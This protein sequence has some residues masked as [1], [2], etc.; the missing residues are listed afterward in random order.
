[1]GSTGEEV[2]TGG[3]VTPCG[4]VEIPEGVLRADGKPEAVTGEG[5]GEEETW[6]IARGCEETETSTQDFP[7]G[8]AER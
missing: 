5:E 6:G 4:E 1:M 8:V 2:E 7:E 3:A